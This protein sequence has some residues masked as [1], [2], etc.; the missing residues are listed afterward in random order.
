MKKTIYLIYGFGKSGQSAFN[1][2]KNKVKNNICY[3]YDD[4]LIT[5]EREQETI[6]KYKD[7]FVLKK[8]NR[9]VIKK[10]DIIVLSPGVSIYTPLIVY[11]KKIKKE[12]ISELEL[13]FRYCKNKLIAITGT[14][15][16]TTTTRLITNILN[17]SGKKA[18]SVGNIGFPLSQAVLDYS[19]KIIFVCEV[20]SFQ[21]EAIKTFKPKVSCLLN[22]TP[23]H[24]DRHRSMCNYRRIK[25]RIF[26][27]QNKSDYLIFNQKI[28]LRTQ[29]KPFKCLSFG[30]AGLNGCCYEFDN[31][32]YFKPKNKVQKICS[33]KDFDLMGKHN[34]E[35]ILCAVAVTKSLKVKNKHIVNALKLFKLDSHRVEKIYEKNNILFYD[36]SKATNIDATIC[37][38]NS[39]K[40]NI[41]LILGGSDKGY[42]YD[43]LLK[44]LPQ[45]VT[46]VLCCGAVRKKILESSQKFNR[47]AIS[48]LTLKEATHYACKIAQP[49]DCVL[50]SPA[51]ASFDEFKNYKH[52]GEKFLEYIREY[53]ETV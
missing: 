20:S 17:Q 33:C 2:I 5:S 7:V 39:F 27:N 24:L 38:V 49:Q 44:K 36:D 14:N 37:A 50:L 32:I 31:N 52:R 23:D 41:I 53:Y 4:S 6:H 10:V 26:F 13:G 15:G 22:I 45:N 16:K 51:C 43:L 35:N 29:N 21:L 25:K 11:A 42:D 40:Q 9:E 3:I 48:F 12:V 30:V 8:I 1:L 46:S 18:V 34:V 28:K 19:K 47:K